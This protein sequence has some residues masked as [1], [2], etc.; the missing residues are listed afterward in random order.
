MFAI[1][2]KGLS[3]N[4]PQLSSF[5]DM[6]NFKPWNGSVSALFP[7]RNISPGFFSQQEK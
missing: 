3:L 7:S 2:P 4:P 1:K 5:T 6:T